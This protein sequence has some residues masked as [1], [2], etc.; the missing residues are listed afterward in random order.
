MKICAVI[1]M[2][3]F[4]ASAMAAM[5]GVDQF[6][7]AIAEPS[8]TL[9]VEYHRTAVVLKA[10]PATLRKVVFWTGDVVFPDWCESPSGREAY[11]GYAN[12]CK[13]GSVSVWRAAYFDIAW[14][15]VRRHL[16]VDSVE[17]VEKF[18]RSEKGE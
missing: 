17:V 8:D 3:V 12:H 6:G 2:C 4:A 7:D 15:I 9:T 5:R 18:E 11:I 13:D 10:K 14:P 16:A 1:L